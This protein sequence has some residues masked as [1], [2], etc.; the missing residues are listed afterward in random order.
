MRHLFDDPFL[1][2]KLNPLLLKQLKNYFEGVNS[3]KEGAPTQTEQAQKALVRFALKKLFQSIYVRLTPKIKGKVFLLS[4][5]SSDG[6]GDYFA[7]HKSAKFIKEH[8]SEI[9][10]Q[11]VYTFERKLPE[12]NLAEY[13]LT[14]EKQHPFYQI[15]NHRILEP[16]LEGKKLPDFDAELESIREN[17]ENTKKDYE[18]V[19]KKHPF[20]ASALADLLEEL[21]SQS[22]KLE[23]FS[24]SKK[25]AEKL[26]QAL[27]DSLAI[28]QIALALNT[29]ENPDLASKSF[30]F[31]ESGNFQGIANCFKYHW[32]SMGLQPFEEGFFLNKELLFIKKK[33]PQNKEHS[34]LCYL[35]KISKQKEIYL[36][37]I[38]LLE[39]EKKSDFTIWMTPFSKNELPTWD[40]NFLGKLGIGKIVSID[41]VEEKEETINNIGKT[42]RL[43]FQLPLP[44]EEFDH[45]VESSLEPIGCTGDLSL[46]Q[47]LSLG[48]IPFYELRAHKMETVQGFIEIAKFLNL[49]EIV[50]YFNELSKY[51]QI[52]PLTVANSLYNIFI[53][54]EFRKEWEKLIIFL[55]KYFCFETSLLAHLNRHFIYNLLPEIEKLEEELILDFYNQ[56]KPLPEIYRFLERELSQRIS[57]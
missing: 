43:K 51:D 44:E 42:L 1:Q 3:I 55:K 7:L 11:V 12:L 41:A 39:K 45:L 14:K 18:I 22:D 2:E 34:F 48:K 20:A 56:K 16:I 38:A 6:L 8:Y 37:L 28:I 50:S 46:S 23:I 24:K 31:A 49:N 36:Y 13:R 19:S 9:D 27:K 15:S 26:Y 53:K 29:F 4:C 21:K 32:F 40:K 57:N 17:Y 52:S 33:K 25:E 10:V 5:I 35:T 30:Y 47:T 54:E